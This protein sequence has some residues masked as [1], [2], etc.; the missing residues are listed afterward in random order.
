MG[1]T[2]VSATRWP[3][4]IDV[5]SPSDYSVRRDDPN[6]T[7]DHSDRRTLRA[8]KTFAHWIEWGD[9]GVRRT[10]DVY[11]GKP[12]AGHVVHYLVGTSDAF[13]TGAA[14]DV[15]V[16]L[17]LGGG[18]W[19]NLATL[20][21]SPLTVVPPEPAPFPSLGFF[22]PTLA[23]G[24][25]TVSPPYSP[26]VRIRPGDEYWAAKRLL[27]GGERAL[28]DGLAAA[29][30]PAE[31]AKTL[32]EALRSRRRQLVEH[33]LSVVTPLDPLATVGRA[34]WVRDRALSA[35]F[36][37]PSTTEYEI[38]FLDADGVAL[39]PAVRQRAGG[40]LTE[41]VVPNGLT[42][43]VVLH[44]RVVRGGVA[45]PR[46]CDLHLTADASSVKLVGVRH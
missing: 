45:A 16:R 13:G 20:G 37:E 12:G 42:G 17:E 3:I 23:A 40:P 27:E 9:F 30:Y 39:S 26:F 34:L 35:G 33:G 44:V 14:H 28:V 29:Q 25:F 38:E 18:F 2:R 11:V 41:I 36:A 31:A 4:G 1:G 43:V 6:D 8:L 19:W 46:W 21:L 22:P 32:G 15:P 24:S 5:G 7:I 10:R